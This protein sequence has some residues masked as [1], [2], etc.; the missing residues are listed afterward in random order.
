[1]LTYCRKCCIW[2]KILHFSLSLYFSLSLNF[3]LS[4]SLSLS[5][6]LI[7]SFI[8]LFVRSVL[9][10]VRFFAT[11]CRSLLAV[12]GRKSF[13]QLRA[14]RMH[15]G[16][17]VIEYMVGLYATR[18]TN[19]YCCWPGICMCVCMCLFI[20]EWFDS[21]VKVN[22]ISLLFLPSCLHMQTQGI[23]LIPRKKL[24]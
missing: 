14:N 2:N 6:L 11:V 8:P 16:I 23:N 22:I 4:L 1:M 10:L 7:A 15:V 21:N 24:L 5:L 20:W 12:E 17:T 3:A 19:Y 13:D 18:C 9:S